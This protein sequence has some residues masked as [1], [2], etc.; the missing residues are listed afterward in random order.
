V[1]QFLPAQFAERFFYNREIPI[2]V[3]LKTTFLSATG[4]CSAGD[5]SLAPV[6]VVHELLTFKPDKNSSNL[7][8]LIS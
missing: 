4:E 3:N 6:K 8:I 1:T 2:G 5:C 7:E